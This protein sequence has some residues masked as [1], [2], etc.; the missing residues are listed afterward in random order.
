MKDKINKIK[1]STDRDYLT[2][3]LKP[4]YGMIPIYFEC[5][6]KSFSPAPNSGGDSA[7]FNLV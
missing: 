6:R 5:N 4:S 1:K 3:A 7:K 2:C